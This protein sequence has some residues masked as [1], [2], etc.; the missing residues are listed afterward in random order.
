MER[1]GVREFR[2]NASVYLKRVQLGERF[3]VTD[4]GTPV[5]ELGPVTESAYDRMVHEGVIVP[6]KVSFD[7]GAFAP[8]ESRP[9]EPTASEAL[10]AMREGERY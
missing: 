9:G 6:A 3:Q 2:Q 8:V 5:A 1:I 10:R 4:R 7:A